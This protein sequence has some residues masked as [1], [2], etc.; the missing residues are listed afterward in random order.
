LRMRLYVAGTVQ[1][2]SIGPRRPMHPQSVL[3]RR[4]NVPGTTRPATSVQDR[5]FGLIKD[6]AGGRIVFATE[7]S[8]SG[9]WSLGG[10]YAIWR[11][12]SNVRSVELVRVAQPIACCGEIG[13]ISCR[14]EIA[15]RR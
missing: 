10:F 4:K 15:K 13:G 1:Y 9:D 8:S 3:R 7:L 5:R 6:D 12:Q 11:G 14:G 2:V